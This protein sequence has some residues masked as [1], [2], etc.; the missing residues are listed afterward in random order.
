VT[1]NW[2]RRRRSPWPP[3]PPA[4][5]SIMSVLPAEQYGAGSAIND[6]VQELGASLGVAVIGSVVAS[7]FRHAESASGLPATTAG[8]ERPAA[9]SRAMSNGRIG[10]RQRLS[11]PT[12]HRFGLCA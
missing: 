2:P 7:P 11:V 8:T 1:D 12:K 5:N 10:T 3:L 6:T 9:P 4:G